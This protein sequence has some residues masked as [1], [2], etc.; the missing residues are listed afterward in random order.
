MFRPVPIPRSPIRNL[1]L[2]AIVNISSDGGAQRDALGPVGQARAGQETNAAD[3]C[4]DEGRCV[5]I[6]TET[7][8][9]M[10]VADIPK[11]NAKAT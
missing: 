6:R 4:A 10:A 1:G 2:F 7:A 9:N 8:E 11:R 3:L 5:A